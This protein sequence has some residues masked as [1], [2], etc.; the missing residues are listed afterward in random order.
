MTRYYDQKPNE[1]LTSDFFSSWFGP[2][3]LGW[4][5]LAERPFTIL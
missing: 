2:A 3:V 5:V 4:I 1:H